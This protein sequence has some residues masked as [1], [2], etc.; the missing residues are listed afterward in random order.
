MEYFQDLA[1]QRLGEIEDLER[2][3]KRLYGNVKV[4]EADF[5]SLQKVK[6]EI[7]EENERHWV[8]IIQQQADY[9]ELLAR[10]NSLNARSRSHRPWPLEVVP[11]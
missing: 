4:T 11:S 8:T 10:Y 5:K 7:Q 3:N 6:Q 1:E 2:H 9:S